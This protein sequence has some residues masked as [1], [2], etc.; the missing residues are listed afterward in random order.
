MNNTVC[1]LRIIIENGL[2][3]IK[4]SS[5]AGL[6]D[7]L[8]LSGVSV[9]AHSTLYDL[10]LDIL[11]SDS[12]YVVL[13][14]DQETVGFGL[15]LARIIMPEHNQVFILSQ[16]FKQSGIIV[17][18]DQSL[19]LIRQ[20]K[21]INHQLEILPSS[22]ELVSLL[23]K[24]EL[25]PE[26]QL[27]MRAGFDSYM[28]GNYYNSSVFSG[29]KHV[30][31]LAESALDLKEVSPDLMN[32]NSAFIFHTETCTDDFYDAHTANPA[33]V[34]A[35]HIHQVSKDKV[36]FDGGK[37]IGIDIIPYA[38]YRHGGSE[39]VYLSI[40]D[41]RDLNKLGEDVQNYADTGRIKSTG[42]RLINSCS[43]NNS[44]CTL[45]QL[46]R[47]QLGYGNE[48]KPCKFSS[49]SIGTIADP[50]F[51]L[52]RKASQEISRQRLQRHCES[53]S[54]LAYCS[55][56][57]LLPDGIAQADFC[58]LMRKYPILPDY[59]F[60]LTLFSEMLTAN[61]LFSQGDVSTV[62]VSNANHPLVYLDKDFK[63]YKQNS[64]FTAFRYNGEYYVIKFAMPKIIRTE[65]R[66]IYI[67]EAFAREVPVEDIYQKYAAKY[68]V[69]PTDAVEHVNEAAKMIRMGN[70]Q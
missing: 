23:Q 53:C 65:E 11:D 9:D 37:P 24:L 16:A 28:T 69:N 17:T 64:I 25:N 48:I 29:I 19:R 38:D 66:F 27:A 1:L 45:P 5:G 57:A 41:E 63:A 39:L 58:E 56:C 51:S 22:Q 52:L 7:N 46:A 20:L 70:I 55:K 68:G 2:Y 4:Q 43:W 40:R 32:A 12:D 42:A 61:Q 33:M 6:P 10:A 59:V 50:L 54:A 30:E 8:R 44:T 67:A 15:A 14:V 34:L 35:S 49:K 62:E 47:V 31:V 3:A 21:E 26:Q 13:E 36:Q 18:N 60:K